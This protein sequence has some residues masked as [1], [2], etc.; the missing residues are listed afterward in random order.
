MGNSELDEAKLDERVRKMSRIHNRECRFYTT[1]GQLGLIPLVGCYYTQELRDTDS[2]PSLSNGLIIMQGLTES[3]YMDRFEEG[4]NKQKVESVVKHLA[5]LHAHLLC[6][7][8][9]ER[10]VEWLKPFETML[11]DDG[12][13][14]DAEGGLIVGMLD[15]AMNLVPE[16]TPYLSRL[17]RALCSKEFW[18][19]AFR[20]Y[21]EQHGIP[22]TLVHGDLWTSNILWQRSNEDGK[23]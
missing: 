10:E 7:R 2:D 11:L 8:E 12:M 17:K 3:A 22:S 13:L 18:N 23:R 9:D 5:A 1:F 16:V 14:D 19:L 21:S 6:H 15:G 4:L 20:D